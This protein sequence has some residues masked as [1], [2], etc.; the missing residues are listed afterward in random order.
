MALEFYRCPNP[1]C[2]NE[3]SVHPTENPVLQNYQVMCGCGY[4]GPDAFSVEDAIVLHNSLCKYCGAAADLI[5]S[6]ENVLQ[7]YLGNKHLW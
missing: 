4:R 5:K 1:K 7:E 6:L 3:C 2:K